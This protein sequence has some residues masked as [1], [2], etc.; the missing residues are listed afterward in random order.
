M[1]I[2]VKY[3]NNVLFTNRDYSFSF[4]FFKTLS[5]KNEF[6]VHIMFVN[7]VAIQMKNASNTFF[8]V[9]KNMRVSNLHDYEKE[10]CYIISIDDRHL[11]VVS[12]SS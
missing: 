10:N 6:F 8:V 5:A 11:V 12:T 2:F 1:T 9:F 7:V 4:K 3:K